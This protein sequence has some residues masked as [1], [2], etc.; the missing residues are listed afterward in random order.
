MKFK[1][2][3]ALGAAAGYLVG[4]GKAREL[5]Q[6][7]K[8]SGCAPTSAATMSST[9]EEAVMSVSP[10]GAPKVVVGAGLPSDEQMTNSLYG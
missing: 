2:G 7:V 4:S 5:V 3:L 1:L 8:D 9:S 10:S 6:M